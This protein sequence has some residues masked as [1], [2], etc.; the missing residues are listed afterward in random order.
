MLPKSSIASLLETI[1][2]KIMEGKL[3]YII[4][5]IDM[6]HQK[7]SNKRQREMEHVHAPLEMQML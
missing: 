2:C 3:T 4:Y 5:Y 6:S 7:T 1:N